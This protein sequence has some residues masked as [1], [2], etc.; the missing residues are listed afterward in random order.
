MKIP[1]LIGALTC[2][3]AAAQVEGNEFSALQFS[4]R[5]ITSNGHI[6]QTK[7][8][9]FDFPWSFAINTWQGQDRQCFYPVGDLFFEVSS[10]AQINELARRFEQVANAK[11][12]FSIVS[13][14]VFYKG[15]AL[16]YSERVRESKGVKEPLGRESPI[17]GFRFTSYLIF[18]VHPLKS[19]AEAP[20]HLVLYNLTNGSFAIHPTHATWPQVWLFRR[21][22]SVP[23]PRSKT[24]ALPWSNPPLNSAPA[25]I[26]SR[27]LS[28]S[29]YL[30]FVHRLGAG[31]AG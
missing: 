26:A 19:S 11:Q 2:L 22:E 4:G 5:S 28:T 8:S 17:Q 12:D 3:A 13:G 25:C 6:D 15:Q 14:R 30:G 21:D 31:V 1:F 24:S 10:Q 29:R 23:D 27:S 9:K 18:M 16:R 7:W 20:F